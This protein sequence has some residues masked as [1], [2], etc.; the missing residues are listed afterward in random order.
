MSS[1]FSAHRLECSGAIWAHC[2]LSL[3]GSS[4]SPAS[5][6]QVTG[7]TADPETSQQLNFQAVTSLE[8][9]KLSGSRCRHQPHFNGIQELAAQGHTDPEKKAP[10]L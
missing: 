3:L 2:N 8:S 4:D 6:S 5:T 1:Q 9:M 7:I 10:C